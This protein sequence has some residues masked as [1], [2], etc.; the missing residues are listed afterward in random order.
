MVKITELNS[1]YI[2]IDCEKSIAKELSSYFTFRVPNFQYTP[3]YKN[4]IWDGK[5]R[6]FNL[7]NG[8]LYRGLLDHLFLFLKDRNYATNFILFILQK[9]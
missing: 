5:I 9:L 6:L 2:K 1:V 7:I 4:R 3:A 8:Y